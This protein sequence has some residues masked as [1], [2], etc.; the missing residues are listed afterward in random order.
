M[1]RAIF[2]GASGVVRGL[3]QRVAALDGGH[4]RRGHRGCVDESRSSPL[5]R[6]RSRASARSR[7]SHRK[8]S[9]ARHARFSSVSEVPAA[10]EPSSQP[11]EPR[12]NA[13]RC[14]SAS[15]RSSRR[16]RSR[17]S[18]CR[19]RCLARISGREIR[20][21]FT[22]QITLVGEVCSEQD[23]LVP[24]RDEDLVQRGGM[25]LR[26]I[27][28]AAALTILAQVAAP[29]AVNHGGRAESLRPPHVD[30]TSPACSS[31]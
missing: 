16:S 8:C 17:V 9:A 31:R 14:R 10:S 29:R 25:H 15:R 3:G 2:I 7:S 24:P 6:M 26:Y 21:R 27:S 1:S 12:R 22:D 28:S 18:S 20:S 11:Q 23:L 30:P 5:S 4:H 19:E 13:L